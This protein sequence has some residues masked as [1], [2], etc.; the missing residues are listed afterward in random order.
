MY[1]YTFM[2]SLWVSLGKVPEHSSVL[3]PDPSQCAPTS[4]GNSWEAVQ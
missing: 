4:C 1:M 3:R 2:S